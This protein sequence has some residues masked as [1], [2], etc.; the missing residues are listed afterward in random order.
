M[1]ISDITKNFGK[2]SSS[3]PIKNID[4]KKL[5]ISLNL[6]LWVMFILIFSTELYALYFYGYKNLVFLPPPETQNSG[7]AVRVNFAHYDKVVKRLSELQGYHA[8]STIDLSG[9]DNRT[10]RTNPFDDPE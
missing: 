7:A 6:A 4:V 2:K 5:N 1:K 9:K 3:E 8:T 10:G